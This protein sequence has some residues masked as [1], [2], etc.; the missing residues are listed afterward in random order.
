MAD[1]KS[2]IA[3]FQELD[4]LVGNNVALDFQGVPISASIT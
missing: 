2:L 1:T 4:R 3:T